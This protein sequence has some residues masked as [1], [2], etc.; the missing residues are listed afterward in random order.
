MSFGK[1]SRSNRR[2]LLW[3]ALLIVLAAALSYG[4]LDADDPPS[5]DERAQALTRTIRCPQCEGETVAESNAPI[6]ADM[7]TDIR[8][9]I[10]RG[11]T[12][13]QIRESYASLYG[14]AVL[15]TPPGEGLSVALWVVP[16]TGAALGAVVLAL[17]Y[18]RRRQSVVEAPVSEAADTPADAGLA[19]TRPTRWLRHWRVVTVVAIVLLGSVA[20]GWFLARSVGIRTSGSEI[21]GDIRQSSRGLLAEAREYFAL[22]DYPS[23]QDAYDQVLELDPNNEVALT[24]QGWLVWQSEERDSWQSALAPDGGSSSA[25]PRLQSMRLLARAVEIA[26]SYPDARAFRTIIWTRTGRWSQAQGDLDVLATLET[27]ASLSNL[28]N[29]FLLEEAVERFQRGDIAGARDR[30]DQVLKLN[31]DNEVA[32]TYQGWLVWQSEERDTWQSVLVPDGGISPATPQLQ[33]M[34]LLARAVEVAP[35]YP[36]ARA[37]RAIIWARTGRW[38]QAQADLDVLD[39]L[40]VP[41]GISDLIDA[42][43]IRAEVEF[44]VGVGTA[45]Q[46]VIDLADQLAAD[47][48]TSITPQV[49][50]QALAGFSP[51][52]LN[53]AGEAL[54][55]QGRISPSVWV[56]SEVLQQD[57]DNLTALTWRGFLH[58][59]PQFLEDEDTDVFD[60]G[61]ADLDRAAKLAPQDNS[62]RILRAKALIAAGQRLET[63]AADLDFIEGN[64]PSLLI[65]QDIDTQRELLAELRI[66]LQG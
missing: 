33:S 7:R 56:F 59:L 1:L 58:T 14:D 39:T 8:D 37:F 3:S 35:S 62:A 44:Q 53:S 17:L 50:A 40:E 65:Q 15:L 19:T 48:A 5:E 38:S 34:R 24:Y 51:E 2:W 52:Q 25:T 16:V 57:P 12:D 32:L 46:N 63:A 22:G 60:R 66:E 13:Q 21:T 55:I 27:S 6:A 31:P 11:Q 47:P 18:R 29:S 20:A 61:L 41:A 36:D 42:L 26:P 54:S 28:I 45:M 9:R 30:Y 23:A 4:I 10:E 43:G 49:V 64:E